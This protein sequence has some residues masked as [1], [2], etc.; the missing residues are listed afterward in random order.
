M[1][2]IELATTII[3]YVLAKTEAADF[4]EIKYTLRAAKTVLPVLPYYET[5]KIIAALFSVEGGEPNAE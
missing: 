4:T 1:T 3:D 5:E 2:D